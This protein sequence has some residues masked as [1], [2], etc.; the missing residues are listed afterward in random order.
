MRLRRAFG[1]L[2]GWYDA[3]ADDLSPIYRDMSVTPASAQRERE[4]QNW[5]MVEALLAGE[6]GAHPA[7]E[8]DRRLLRALA[9]HLVD[10]RTWRALAV[11]A[12]LD[13]REVVELAVRLLTVMAGHQAPRRH[14][15]AG[16]FD[17]D[18]GERTAHQ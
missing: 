12:E 7:P 16:Q 1:E 17:L 3:H 10:F 9:R 18:P 4:A 11:Q 8:M 6:V 2:Y 5:R 14:E 15:P 13:R